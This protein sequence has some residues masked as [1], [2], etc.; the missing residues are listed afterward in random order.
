VLA[1]A[2]LVL[3]YRRGSGIEREQLKWFAVV[4]AI[5]GPALVV[6]ALTFNDTSGLGAEVST[7]AFNIS[8]L[9]MALLPVAIGIAIL[10]YRLYDIDL[11]IRRTL[12]YGVLA[13]LLAVAYGGSVLLLSAVLAPLTAENSLAVAG[14]TL[15]VAALFSPVRN[16]VRSIVDR[17]F[18]RS[19]YDAT[20]ELADL[21]QRLRGEVDLDGV[22][23]E[24]VATIGRTLQPTSASIWLRPAVGVRAQI[25]RAE[26]ADGLEAAAWRGA[27]DGDWLESGAVIDGASAG[28]FVQY[29]LAL[30][31]TNSGSTPRIRRVTIETA[32]R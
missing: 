24:V 22:K 8:S 2:S 15:L 31:A 17:R 25:R 7:A 18:Y 28:G 5:A 19:R 14:S 20:R 10:R 9:G 27:V 26:R 4:M 29:R 6:G 3:R 1:L 16:R 11:V 13:V 32:V 23:A 12:V 30:G 21:S